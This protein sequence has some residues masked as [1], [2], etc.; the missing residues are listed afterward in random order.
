MKFVGNFKD[1]IQDQWLVEFLSLR[2]D[3]RPAEGQK[4][5]TPEMLEEYRKALDAGYNADEIYF[6]MFDKNNTPFD[7]PRP[8]WI[9]NNKKFHWWVTKMLP[10]QFMP[11]H[12][13]PH[14]IYENNSDRYW[15]PLHDWSPGHIFVYEDQVI[16][17]YK[18]GDVWVYSD[19]TALH[20]AANIGYTPRVIL[21]I[22][23]HD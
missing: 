4:P 2:G 18:A 15:V 5:N 8:P 10:G 1:W 12:I 21:Q 13:D 11:I 6:W 20:G 19:S 3:G 17:N 16:T 22:S 14:T 7:I 9:G 23:T